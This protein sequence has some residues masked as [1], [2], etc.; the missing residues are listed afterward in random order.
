M[1]LTERIRALSKSKIFSATPRRFALLAV[2]LVLG[3]TAFVMPAGAQDYVT[4]VV[5]PGDTLGKIAAR[6]CADWQ[7]V[8]NINRQ[9]IGNNPNQIEAGM[10]LTVPNRCGY[11]P[12]P[13][14][15]APVPPGVYDRGPQN[16][17]TGTIA[18][19]YYTVAWGDDL[20]AIGQRFGVPAAAIAQANE[21]TNATSIQPGQTLYIPGMGPRE[22]VQPTATPQP[23]S[24]PQQRTFAH[25]ECTISFSNN[26][27]SHFSPQQGAS[28]VIGAGS[29]MALE[30]ANYN[31]VLWYQLSVGPTVPGWI[32]S[33]EVAYS[34]S[35]NC[36][37]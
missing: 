15:P 34:T 4:V 18:G 36:G 6:Y 12:T 3:L 35:G 1:N 28:G 14:T 26:A 9:T 31:G 32:S 11:S 27:P 7:E 2:L 37:L 21:L 13:S 25:G 33:S 23:P 29:Y 17:A 16:Q 8:Y 19:P 10:V 20:F 22:P 24:P 5:Q 30:V